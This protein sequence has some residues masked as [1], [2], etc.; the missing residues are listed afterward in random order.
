MELEFSTNSQLTRVRSLAVTWKLTPSIQVE[1]IS[2]WTFLSQ[3]PQDWTGFFCAACFFQRPHWVSSYGLEM[4][5]PYHGHFQDPDK[6]LKS[7]HMGKWCVSSLNFWRQSCFCGNKVFFSLVEFKEASETHGFLFHWTFSVLLLD[8]SQC[9]G[10]QEAY[11]LTGSS[12]FSNSSSLTTCLKQQNL[13]LS[14]ARWIKFL[15]SHRQKGHIS[16]CHLD[17]WVCALLPS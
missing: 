13:G 11:W 17:Y 9:W 16:F 4:L 2:S 6:T 8:S 10:L 12:F 14:T 5:L 3:E 7:W 1:V 15:F